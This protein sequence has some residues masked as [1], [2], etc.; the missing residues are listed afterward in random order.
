MQKSPLL[1][2]ILF[3]CLL[4]IGVIKTPPSKVFAAGPGCILMGGNTNNLAQNIL[5]FNSILFNTNLAFEY[6]A[7]IR[8]IGT[9][10]YVSDGW[11]WNDN[12]GWLSLAARNDPQNPGTK[13]NSGVTINSSF[14]YGINLEKTFSK[15]SPRARLLGYIWGDNAGW[16]KMNCAEDPSINYDS[17]HCGAQKYGV[18]V[19]FSR[20]VNNLDDYY[21]LKGYAWSPHYGYIDFNSV[22][23]AVPDVNYDF[24]PNVKYSDGSQPNYANGTATDQNLRVQFFSKD[25]PSKNVTQF[26]HASPFKFCL[27]FDDQR[28][29]N[30]VDRFT[31]ELDIGGNI[32]TSHRDDFL[33]I[34]SSDAGF[35]FD[36]NENAYVLDSADLKTFLSTQEGDLKLAYVKLYSDDPDVPSQLYPIE[37]IKLDFVPPYEVYLSKGAH[38]TFDATKAAFNDSIEFDY[39]SNDPNDDKFTLG[40]KLH[41]GALPRSRVFSYDINIGSS[42]NDLLNLTAQ[43]DLPTLSRRPSRFSCTQNRRTQRLNVLPGLSPAFTILNRFD[44]GCDEFVIPLSL[45]ISKHVSQVPDNMLATSIDVDVKYPFSIRG[46]TVNSQLMASMIRSSNFETFE[47]FMKGFIQDRA[48]NS[49]YDDKDAS[50]NTNYAKFKSLINRELSKADYKQCSFSDL[51]TDRC[52]FEDS[53]LIV[54]TK[55]QGDPKF[56]KLQDVQDGVFGLNQDSDKTVLLKGF[57]IY[58]DS[59]FVSE[60]PFGIVALSNEAQG[61]RMYVDYDVTKIINLFVY[62][63]QNFMSVDGIGDVELAVNG[64]LSEVGVGSVVESKSFNQLIFNGQLI[65]N[66][67]SGCSR[68]SDD[69]LAKFADGRLVQSDEDLVLAQQQDLNL[70]RYSPLVLNV[71]RV[72][73]VLQ[74]LDC[75]GGQTGQVVGRS[76]FNNGFSLDKLCFM[77]ERLGFDIKRSSVAAEFP[78]N[79]QRSFMLFYSDPGGLPMFSRVEQ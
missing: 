56:I 59:D 7:C 8:P 78:L 66:N 51:N 22:V 34:L 77:P 47:S 69:E 60:N 70:L 27:A 43:V 1:K 4:L 50:E 68:A 37:D 5:D 24:K 67:C 42:D 36:F 52:L 18:E 31:E 25:D 35:T 71:K 44:T 55:T 12:L 64:D 45:D 14:E 39:T 16:I 79:K 33:N 21:Y 57:D 53:N 20:P 2:V 40:V 65:S 63:D 54:I 38:N 48:F 6:K 10:K 75:D 19:D 3:F 72:N 13:I 46:N 28:T 23:I 62:L 49:V 15:G 30:G 32:C 41:R 9:G 29:T 61:G 76:T 11:A 17:N 26:F 58:V 73:G 74:L